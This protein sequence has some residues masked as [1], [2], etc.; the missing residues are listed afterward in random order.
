MRNLA[1]AQPARNPRSG[2]FPVPR[3][4]CALGA[5]SWIGP[6]LPPGGGGKAERSGYRL[7]AMIE[8][9]TG[10]THDLRPETAADELAS[11]VEAR[12]GGPGRIAGGL[13]VANAASGRG[14]PEIGRLLGGRWPEATLLGS[15]FEGVLAEG[16]V[17]R[18]QPAAALVA[19]T[20]GPEEP[21]PLFFGPTECG[22][23]ELAHDI[24]EDAERAR[25]EPGD[26][27]LLFPDS[28]ASTSL[29]S[30]LED[31]LPRLGEPSVAGA[32]ATGVGG[33]G[34]L[35]WCGAEEKAAA[36]VGLLVPGGAAPRVPRAR[37]AGGSRPASPWLEISACRER[38]IDGLE[39]EP[40]LDWVR[41]QLGLADTQ[42]VEPYLSRLLVRLRD[43]PPGPVEQRIPGPNESPDAGPDDYVER[44]VVGLDERRGALAVAGSFRRGGQLALAL[45]DPARARETLRAAV[46]ALPGSPILM[47]LACRS[48]DE[49]L[50]G[51]ADLESALVAHEA[52]GRTT[53]GVLAPFQLGTDALGRCRMRVHTTVLASLGPF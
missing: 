34:C 11:V 49:L 12:L 44:Y 48:R 51:D 46:E 19:W 10:F 2:P 39:G 47:Q 32:A 35:A 30:M 22:P 24:L 13:L 1:D 16:R 4:R 9:S 15:S 40:P 38:W 7:A 43:A 26:L 29:E 33:G 41:R 8:F 50:H 3:G 23:A 37:C 27:L 5:A 31:L 36:T 6:S 53:L 25:L 45:P 52:R 42:T 17:W 21:V 20:H 18:D 14:G 28:L